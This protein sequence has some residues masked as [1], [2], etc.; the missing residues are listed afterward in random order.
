MILLLD[1]KDSFVWNLAQ[2]LQQLG[3]AVEVVRSDA[4][5]VEALSCYAALVVSPGPGRPESAGHSVAAIQRWSGVLPILGV[6]LGHQAIGQAFGANILRGLPV[7]VLLRAMLDCRDMTQLRALVAANAPGKASHIL[8][9]DANGEYLSTEFAGESQYSLK[10]HNGLLWHSNHYLAADENTGE[11][12]YST[13]ERK[14]SFEF[15]IC[16]NSKSSCLCHCFYL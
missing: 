6:C 4:I 9:G 15:I 3:C 13:E 16:Q 5:E 2:A 11:A 8:A 12:F 10:T 14:L 1:N 7:H